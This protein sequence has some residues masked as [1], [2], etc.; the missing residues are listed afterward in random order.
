V[1][2][3]PPGVLF[4]PTQLQISQGGVGVGAMEGGSAGAAE[5]KDGKIA[6]AVDGG[7]GGRKQGLLREHTHEQVPGRTPGPG[8]TVVQRSMPPR[9]P[10]M[11]VASMVQ[12]TLGSLMAVLLMQ[13]QAVQG[14]GV[15]APVGDAVVG[16]RIGGSEGAA[17]GAPLGA[18]EGLASGLAL[19]ASVG[20]LLGS[21][22][23]AWLGS[24]LGAEVGT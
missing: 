14:V 11:G 22:V 18:S 16:A 19:G 6:G 4:L 13:V 15:G 17:A 2:L 23:G 24:W 5:G 7:D 20:T 1:Q 10:P 12:V 8:S 3:R 21:W 9:Q